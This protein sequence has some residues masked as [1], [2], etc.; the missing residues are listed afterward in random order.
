MKA[1][2]MV[3]NDIETESPIRIQPARRMSDEEYFRF[4]AA[5]PDLRIERTAEGEI[6]IMPPTGFETG[7][8]N[9]DLTMQFRAW[10]NRD[11]R[12]RA[13]DSSTGYLLPSGAGRSADVSWVSRSRLAKLTPEQKKKFLRLC[14]DFVAELRSPSDRLR[15]VQAKMREWMDNGA[16]L[17]W[18]I[19][20]ETPTVYVYRPG[21]ATERLVD[22]HC[23]EGE[24]PIHGFVL[25]MADIW[26]PDL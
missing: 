5:N 16:K 3:L 4:C 14:P 22:P 12:G 9:A 6:E 20:P 24:P 21:Q 1:M 19:D 26:N 25:E 8:Q 18:L 7:D 10:A 2:Q 11:G 17:G 23:V 13:V 15:Q